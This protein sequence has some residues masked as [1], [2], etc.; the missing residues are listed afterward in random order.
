VA[1]KPEM[2]E[3]QFTDLNVV[4][5]SIDVSRE[6]FDDAVKLGRVFVIQVESA[7]R[8]RTGDRDNNAV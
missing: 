6:R 7:V 4:L 1:E 5:R 2:V 8:T 3:M